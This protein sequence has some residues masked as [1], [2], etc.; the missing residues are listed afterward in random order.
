MKSYFLKNLKEKIKDK[1]V[2]IYGAGNYGRTLYSF[3][4]EKCICTI[5]GFVISSVSADK[6]LFEKNIYQ[7]HNLDF[8]KEDIIIIAVS[9]KYDRE[10]IRLLRD[11]NLSNYIQFNEEEWKIIKDNTSFECIKPRNNIAVLLYHRILESE[12]NFWQLNVTPT[13]FEKHMKYISENFHL[14]RLE[15]D[16]KKIVNENE[17]YIVVTFDDGY[18]DNYWNALPILEK[19]H[20]PATVFVSTDLIGTNEMYWWDELE[21]YF[22]LN[23]YRGTFWFEGK[24]YTI[25]TEEDAKGTC[26]TIRNYLKKL[27]S[28][29]RK[30]KMKELRKIL[31]VEKVYDKMLR[32]VNNNELENMAKSPWVSIGAHTKSHLSLSDCVPE[33]ILNEEILTSKLILEKIIG[34][35]VRTF[36]YPYGDK[37]DRNVLVKAVAS[38]IGIEKVLTV[39]DG[40]ASINSDLYNIPRHMILNSDNI[41]QKL[42]KI[43]GLYG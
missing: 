41:E 8:T 28:K 24:E 36:A 14:L 32:C 13:T 20:I 40:N 25:F 17:K 31:K 42:K 29:E 5:K 18:V 38:K 2:Y 27:Y 3:L 19:Y 33:K 35:E 21:N 9:D 22:I 26:I 16:W 10:I 43:W 4:Q 39:E 11:K 7:F 30:T 37:E 23:K 6:E 15:D 1:N 34:K 12:Y